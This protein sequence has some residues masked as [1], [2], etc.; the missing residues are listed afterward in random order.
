LL[1]TTP[2]KAQGCGNG[3]KLNM[4]IKYTLLLFFF[5]LISHIY[6]QTTDFNKGMAAFNAQDYK[7]A[8][9]LLAPYAKK[10]NCTAQY[11]IGYSFAHDYD[12]KND[13]LA[14]HWLLLAAEQKQQ[15]A[16]GP[17][18]TCYFWNSKVPDHLAKAYL[19]GVLGELYDPAQHPTGTTL[20]AKEYMKPDE[21][22]RANKLIDAY[23]DRWHHKPNCQ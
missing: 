12:L 13:S 10:G 19:W 5:F 4:K 23:E 18:S 2:T 20:M 11:A 1:V 21:L 7:T 14:I 6:A 3:E 16:M 22:A 9:L 15:K 17:L 8:M